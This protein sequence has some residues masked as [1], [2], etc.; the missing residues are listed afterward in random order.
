MTFQAFKKCT[1]KLFVISFHCWVSLC[2]L[3]CDTNLLLH[4]SLYL[5]NAIVYIQF[6][7]FG[8]HFQPFL[9]LDFNFFPL[10][11]PK[12][13]PWKWMC[14]FPLF[15]FIQPLLKTRFL[16]KGGVS[17]CVSWTASFKMNQVCLAANSPHPCWRVHFLWFSGRVNAVKGKTV[18][19]DVL[20]A[21]TLWQHIETN[22]WGWITRKSVILS[23]DATE[24]CEM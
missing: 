11:M 13:K 15:H 8:N 17:A 6:S 12:P 7:I 16:A 10:P 24:Q 20:I 22:E 4:I 5:L 14:I 19:M 2:L 1:C 23:T 18:S 3:K 21:V 9:F